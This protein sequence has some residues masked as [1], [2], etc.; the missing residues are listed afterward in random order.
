M[1]I[2]LF[3]IHFAGKFENNNLFKT[4]GQAEVNCQDIHNRPEPPDPG[5]LPEKIRFTACPHPTH[6]LSTFF[7]QSYTHIFFLIISMLFLSSS[8]VASSSEIL[9]A[10]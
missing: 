5:F 8:L 2:T 10:P 3:I 6:S 7:K 4:D 1:W 9:F